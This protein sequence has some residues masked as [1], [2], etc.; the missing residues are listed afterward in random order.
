MKVDTH[1]HFWNLDKVDYPWLT[2]AYGPL[3]RTYEPPELE[4]QLKAAGIDRTVLVQS[5]NSYADTDAMLVH[6][7]TYDWIGAVIGRVPLLEP[8]EAAR[9]LDR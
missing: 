1:Q 8:D 4:P 2:P 7:D 3:Y 5:A 6:A 9:A